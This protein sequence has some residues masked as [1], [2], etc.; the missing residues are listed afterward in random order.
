MTRDKGMRTL[1]SLLFETA[2]RA[3]RA[4]GRLAAFLPPP[5]AGRTLV[6]GAGKAA[7]AMAA[8]L[9]R[10]WPGELEGAVVTRYGYTL[11]TYAGRIRVLE[12]AHPVPDANSLAAA[13]ILLDLVRGLTAE[14]L[15]IALLSG[16]ASALLVSPVAGM[17][18]TEKQA[19]NRALLRSGAAID[20]MNCV[21]KH[22][23]AI[24]GGRL[25]LAALPAQVLTLAIS[26]IPG[27]D[28]TV[29]GSGPTL[30]DPTSRE[31]AL[32]ILDRYG[33]DIPAAVRTYLY[34]PAGETPKPGDPRLA[35]VHGHIV[36]RPLD[37]LQ[38]AAHTAQAAGYEPVILG[39]ALE[40]EARDLGAQQAKLALAARAAGRRVCLLSGGETTV[41]LRGT[42]R[43]GRN[44]EYLLGLAAALAGAAGIH[45]LAGDT[46]GI[47][48]SEENAGAFLSPDSLDR[49][50]ALG[51]DPEAALDN[52][53]AYSFFQALGDLLVTGPTCTNVND[54]RAIL[55]DP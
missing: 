24:K 10:L 21:R 19:V 6:I 29:I 50:R 23:S 51:I 36:V 46:D 32:A 45:A 2:V 53:D 8:E 5:P 20:E 48:G 31:E 26:D 30:P 44:S 4:E 9:D 17:T 28:I 49:A 13:R 33:I 55:V 25:A 39:D 40:G 22:L 1:L 15:V 12:A 18:L 34:S 43:G 35:R 7:A 54:F 14:D 16:G 37:A 52:N 41:T 47:D 27:D 3:G 38:A 11:P 42:G